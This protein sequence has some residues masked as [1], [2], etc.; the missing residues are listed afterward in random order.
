VAKAQKND[1]KVGDVFRFEV[2]GL[3][4]CG[5]IVVSGDTLYVIIYSDT[6][7]NISCYDELG[8]RARIALCG[9]TLDGLIYHGRWKIIG[10]GPVPDAIPRPCYKVGIEGVLWVE[11]FDGSIERKATERDNER[12]DYRTTVAPVRFEKAWAALHG[13]LEWDP[14]FDKI[15]ADYALERERAC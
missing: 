8:L 10:N 13:L 4:G 11:S 3:T 2:A 9:W 1:L 14:S 6:Y 12:L 7:P 15:R 5:H